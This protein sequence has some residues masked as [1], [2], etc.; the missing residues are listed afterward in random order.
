MRRNWISCSDPAYYNS[1]MWFNSEGP[2]SKIT[3]SRSR[4][5]T[6]RGYRLWVHN[7]ETEFHCRMELSETGVP[8]GIDFPESEYYTLFML[9][10][11]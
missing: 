11:Q 8:L 3:L 10:W 5:R 1:L 9:K 6:A 4:A 7:Y 2:G